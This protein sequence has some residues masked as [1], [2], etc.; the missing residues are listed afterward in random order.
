MIFLKFF[1]YLLFLLNP[2]FSSGGCW[3]AF[4]TNLL[5]KVS[6]Q[7]IKQN[8]NSDVYENLRL[9]QHTKEGQAKIR[10]TIVELDQKLK[11]MEEEKNSVLGEAITQS[12]VVLN[13]LGATSKRDGRQNNVRQMDLA[14]TMDS[15]RG[16]EDYTIARRIRDRKWVKYEALEKQFN[17]LQDQKRKWEELLIPEQEEMDHEAG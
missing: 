17:Q 6:K 9:V 14:S 15:L 4:F 3:S 16:V 12:G 11:E 2:A 7:V 13:A 5:G 10:R 8:T 1:F